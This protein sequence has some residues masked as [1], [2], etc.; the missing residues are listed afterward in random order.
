[1]YDLVRGYEKIEAQ[2]RDVGADIDRILAPVM[3]APVVE[4]V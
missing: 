3:S 2:L 1:V 4:T